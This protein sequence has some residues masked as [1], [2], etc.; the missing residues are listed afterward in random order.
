[1]ARIILGPQNELLVD[2][3]AEREPRSKR[4]AAADEESPVY[5]SKCGSKLS[6]D[7]DSDSLDEVEDKL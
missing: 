4:K 6:D 2:H 7:G 5:C 3:T 1:M